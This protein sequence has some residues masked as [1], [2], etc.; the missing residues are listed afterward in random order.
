M[1]IMK[2]YQ[3]RTVSG[4]NLVISIHGNIANLNELTALNETGSFLWN[5]LLEDTN[6]ESLV[7]KLTEEYDVAYEEA[8]MDVQKFLEILSSSYMLE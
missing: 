5:A 6:K 7:N 3:L 4:R 8:R 1:K 2:E